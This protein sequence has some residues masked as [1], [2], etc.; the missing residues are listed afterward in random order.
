MTGKEKCEFLR[1]IRIN[2]AVKNGIP[3]IPKEC[4]NEGNCLG[5]C[6]QCEYETKILMEA[7]QKKMD[8]QGSVVIDSESICKLEQLQKDSEES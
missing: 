8:N 5:S 7:L 3:Y 1:N 4:T 6:P 2:M